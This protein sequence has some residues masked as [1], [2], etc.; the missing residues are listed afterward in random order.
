MVDRKARS[1]MFQMPEQ[2]GLGDLKA[3][4][5]KEIQ[6][7]IV[8][9]QDLGEIVN[10]LELEFRGDA[11]VLINNGFNVKEFYIDCSPPYD[12]FLNVSI[13][14]LCSYVEDEE[15]KSFV[16][17]YGELKSEVVRLR[18]HGRWID[19]VWK[20]RSYAGALKENP[21]NPYIF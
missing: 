3:G 21:I 8:V 11:E 6:D 16:S 1:V 13:M 18:Y 4:I 12:Q 14:G 20:S 9:V 15:V 19:S 17:E 5:Q 7:T 10:L 2:I